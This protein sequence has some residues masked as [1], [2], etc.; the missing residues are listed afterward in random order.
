V[1]LDAGVLPLP[2]SRAEVGLETFWRA[3]PALR[4]VTDETYVQQQF[5]PE[6][7]GLVP[8]APVHVEQPYRTGRVPGD[9]IIRWKRRARLLAAD[10]WAGLEIPLGEEVEAWRVEML[11]GATVVRVLEA[12]TPSALCTAAQQITDRGALLGPGDSLA[13]RIRQMSAIGPGTPATLTLNF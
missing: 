5:V 12:T 9:L 11:G 7:R 6:G 10:S 4:P 13:V 8:F 3:G 2:I 1:L